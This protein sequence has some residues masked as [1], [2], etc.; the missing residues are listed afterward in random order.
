VL[1][2][3]D[4]RILPI[5]KMI[6]HIRI[7]QLLVAAAFPLLFWSC[8]Q[9]EAPP[10]VVVVIDMVKFFNENLPLELPRWHPDPGGGAVYLAGTAGRRSFLINPGDIDRSR[11][12]KDTLH[13][14]QPWSY[15]TFYDDETTSYNYVAAVYAPEDSSRFGANAFVLEISTP[16]LFATDNPDDSALNYLAVALHE[17]AHLTENYV[18]PP[19]TLPMMLQAEAYEKDSLLRSAVSVENEVLLA[20]LAAQDFAE[21]NNQLRSYLSLKKNRAARQTEAVNRTEDYFELVEGYGRFVEHL[22]QERA[23]SFQNQHLLEVFGPIPDYDLDEIAWMYQ[24]KGNDYFYVLGFNKLRLL[25][26]AADYSFVQSLRGESDKTL[27]DYLW[28]V[29]EE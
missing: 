7:R 16:E 3:G 2:S 27:D 28:D 6:C 4:D 24:T 5:K 10:E 26:A 12:S 1:S 19:G 20:A 25:A 17:L 11:F 22:V 29:L 9:K 14:A 21:R 13:I 18:E 23:G 15:L 8:Q